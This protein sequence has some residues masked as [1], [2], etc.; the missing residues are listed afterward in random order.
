MTATGHI[1]TVDIGHRV[2]MNTRWPVSLYLSKAKHGWQVVQICNG[3]V[4]SRRFFGL[5]LDARRYMQQCGE[6]TPL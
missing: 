6:V 4:D 3:E 2:I 1:A 5:E